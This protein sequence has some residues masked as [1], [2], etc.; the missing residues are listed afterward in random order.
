MAET[1]TLTC[2]NCGDSFEKR[3]SLYKEG[4][5]H[6]CGSSC[7]ASFNNKHRE[8][9]KKTSRLEKWLNPRLQNNF[10]GLEIHFNKKNAINS[11]LDIYIPSL[12]LA[13][14]LNGELHYKNIFSQS[15]LE[16][17]QKNDQEKVI[18]C[19]EAG[20]EL[21]VIDTSAAQYITTKLGYRYLIQV[22]GIIKERLNKEN[23]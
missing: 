7:A 18:A 15:M 10:P 6:F 9:G 5:G 2:D 8:Q 3:K 14:E 13:I 12:K 11:E 23:K 20:I 19:K 17:I 22:A 4:T 1:L 16:S 21:V